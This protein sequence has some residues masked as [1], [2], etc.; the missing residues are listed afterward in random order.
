MPAYGTLTTPSCP[1]KGDSYLLWNNETPP[2][3]ATSERIAVS[4]APDGNPAYYSIQI[5]FAGA[6]GTFEIDLQESDT[7]TDADYVT[8]GTG[9]TTVDA[10]NVARFNTPTPVLANFLRLIMKT[11]SSNSEAVTAQITRQ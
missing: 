6:P 5:V 7:D 1:Y 9:T 2:T 11:Q 3:G 4:Y 8:T 10:N